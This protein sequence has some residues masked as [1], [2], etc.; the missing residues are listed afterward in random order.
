M[1]ILVDTHIFLW[2]LSE[3]QRIPADQFQQLSSL[4]NTVHVSAV[5][6]SEIMIKASV[7]KLGVGFD[8]LDMIDRCGFTRLEYSCEDAVLLSQLPFHH[9]DPFDRMLVAQSLN[10]G[11]AIATVDP[12]FRMYDCKLV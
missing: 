8:P 1:N 3:P 6:I 9:R 11:F 12:K 10:R 4:A 7:G 5:S 2:S